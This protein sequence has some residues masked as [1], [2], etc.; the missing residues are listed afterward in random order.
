MRQQMPGRQ[1]HLVAL[2]GH[3]EDLRVGET[4]SICGRLA[5]ALLGADG[6]EEN[7]P[8]RWLLDA[9]RPAAATQ[10]ESPKLTGLLTTGGHTTGPNAHH[11]M[12]RCHTAGPNAN[13]LMLRCILLCFGTVSSWHQMAFAAPYHQYRSTI[14]P[15]WSS[16]ADDGGHPTLTTSSIPP[17]VRFPSAA[18]KTPS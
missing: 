5:K 1:T 11:L 15:T 8:G 9:L 4:E 6:N 7:A 12:L 13:H 2:H 18:G 16:L 17:R 3:P 10:A 14:G